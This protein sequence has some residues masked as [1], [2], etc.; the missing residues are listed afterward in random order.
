MKNGTV[1]IWMNLLGFDKNDPD[2]G[3]KRFLAR[4]GF[5]PDGISALLC[6]PDFYNMHSGMDEEYV[7]PPDNCAY[8]GIPRNSEREGQEWTNYDVRALAEN[9]KAESIEI[10]GGIFGST[11]EN[12]FHREWIEFNV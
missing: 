2:R 10:Y 1:T 8:R 12:A 11:L 5:K 6:P 3:V 9:L 4:T 7:L